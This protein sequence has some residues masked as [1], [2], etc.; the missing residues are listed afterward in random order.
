MQYLVQYEKLPVFSF[1]T[2]IWDMMS[3]NVEMAHIVGR[4]ANGGI[5]SE[6]PFCGRWE[7]RKI[8]EEEEGDVVEGEGEEGE[9]DKEIMMLR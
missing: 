7:E 8:G 9:E 4:S 5:G 2:D 6:F 3:Q 1:I